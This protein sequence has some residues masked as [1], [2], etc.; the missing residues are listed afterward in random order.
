MA[1]I[2]DAAGRRVAVLVSGADVLG[3]DVELPARSGQRAA[4]LA[5]FALEEQLAADIESQHFAVG[6]VRS[7][8]R[9][10]VAVVTRALLEEWLAQLAESG[11]QPD[12]LCA[13]TALLPR[14]PGHTVT[15][16]EGD[17][18]SVVRGDEHDAPLSIAAPAGGFAGAIAI[19]CG[20]EL[21]TTHLLF[22]ATPLEWQRRSAEIEAARPLLAS[23]KVQLLSSGALP[24]LGTQLQSAAPVNLLQGAYARRQSLTAGWARWRL[25]ASLAGG[26]LL[27]H[28]ASQGYQ[29][30]RLGRTSKELDVAI[31]TLAGPQ[32]SEGSGSIRA[33]LEQRLQV[34]RSQSGSSGLLP[35]LQ[36]LAQAMDGV[37]GARVEA[38]NFHD[39]ALQLKLRAADAQSL[40]RIN[41]TLRAAG[42]RADLVSGGA[43]G[44]AY[45]GNIQL[46]G[47]AS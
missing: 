5:P 47:G 30:W 11:I 14:V 18:L 31:A 23:L 2:A 13:D 6:R 9:T 24:W 35:A 26:L 10:A 19:A 8:G 29:L 25:A 37:P 36:V 38:L 15:L 7:D 1:H 20:A 34:A 40:D 27:L 3:L 21:A 12:L 28:L 42:W 4:A 43:A 32:W 33:R 45:E 17:T 39:G 46:R 44:D 41:R 22:H 16:L